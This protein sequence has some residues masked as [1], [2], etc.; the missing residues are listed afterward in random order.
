MGSRSNIPDARTDHVNQFLIKVPILNTIMVFL[1]IP[2]I[3]NGFSL[4]EA[5]GIFFTVSIKHFSD[6]VS[7]DQSNYPLSNTELTMW[8]W[9]GY[10]TIY[11]KLFMQTKLA[12]MALSCPVCSS[13]LFCLSD[14][15]GLSVSSSYF[16]YCPFVWFSSFGYLSSVTMLLVGQFLMSSS[17]IVINCN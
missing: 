12:I 11:R 1:T 15:S 2:N 16:K 9:L 6:V 13:V 10:I 7:T 14:L 4:F 3:S 5:P 17:I 8:Y